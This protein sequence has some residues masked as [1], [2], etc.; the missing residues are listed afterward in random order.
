M[1]QN[2]QIKI[3]NDAGLKCKLE[4]ITD[5]NFE[6]FVIRAFALSL[7]RGKTISFRKSFYNY[8]RIRGESNDG[9]LPS[10]SPCRK[11]EKMRI[12]IALLEREA[13]FH[14]CLTRD[15]FI[16]TLMNLW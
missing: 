14:W 12:G 2:R 4:R 15:K 10:P 3:A 7:S 1:N 11:M 16:E 6:S 9:S 13:R 5:L 8:L